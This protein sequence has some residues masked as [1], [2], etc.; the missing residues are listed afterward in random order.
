MCS[1]FGINFRKIFQKRANLLNHFY[2][3]D[4]SS[5][6]I[7]NHKI[8]TVSGIIYQVSHWLIILLIKRIPNHIQT[9]GPFELEPE[10]E[11]EPQTLNQ[12]PDPEP[13]PGLTL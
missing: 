8:T 10:L 9:V 7:Q 1:L 2:L 4:L 11:P 5:E 13:G 3:D 12:N 6:L